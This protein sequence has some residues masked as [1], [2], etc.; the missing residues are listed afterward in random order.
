MLPSKTGKKAS[1]SAQKQ[2]TETKERKQP[3]FIDNMI[4]YIK[5]PKESIFK[6]TPRTNKFSKLTGNRPMAEINRIPICQP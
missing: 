4:V 1:M 6:N 5:N 3:L 2:E